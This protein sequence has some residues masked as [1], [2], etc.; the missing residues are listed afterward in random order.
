VF[1]DAPSTL[2]IPVAGVIVA[3]LQDTWGAPR[4]EGRGH[5]GIDIF[6]P[7]GAAVF[8]ATDGVIWKVG[9]NRLGGNA[10]WIL[11]PGGQ[12]HY[13]AHLQGFA[14][15]SPRNRIYQGEILGYVGNTGNAK[16]T[17]PHLH[18]AIYTI[19]GSAIN[20]YPL[21]STP[22]NVFAALR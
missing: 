5:Q 14:D 6:A 7:R 19:S 10:V 12:M 4:S 16:G 15:I 18:Y 2:P 9:Q 21:L 1:Q 11:G 13:Y 20:P 8:S 17:P 22:S 3:N